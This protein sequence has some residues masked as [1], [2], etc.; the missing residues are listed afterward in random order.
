MH[1]AWNVILK[2]SGD[3]LLTSGRAMIAGTAVGLPLAVIAWFATG[4]P[5]IPA[6]AFFLGVVSGL[7]EV[8]YLVLLSGAYRRGDL[9]VVYPIARGTAPLLAIVAGV[10]LLGE[11][12]GVVA[13]AGVACLVAGLLIVQRP[14]RFLRRGAAI[15]AAVP[16]AL[17][18][19][20]SIAAYSTVD[21][22]GSRLV[23]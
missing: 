3:P 10:V 4:S 18:C 15:E 11:R 5:A 1:A 13:W 7:I 19:G 22:V 8:V 6:D 16:W 17:A 2:T 21:R 9:S 14:W 20:F 23:A 12:L